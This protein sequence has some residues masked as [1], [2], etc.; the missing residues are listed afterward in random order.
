MPGVALWAWMGF[1]QSIKLHPA[2]GTHSADGCF[3]WKFGPCGPV[4][5]FR[6]YLLPWSGIWALVSTFL[7]EHI[8]ELVDW[9]HYRWVLVS[10]EWMRH[11][12]QPQKDR[13][14]AWEVN[15]A[16]CLTNQAP[17]DVSSIKV[18]A[19]SGLVLVLL[20]VTSK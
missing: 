8:P 2:L 19:A 10:N 6:L 18:R 11:L 5:T 14:W 20:N 7:V 9:L 15:K 13:W 1:S 12:T 4:S 3:G 16:S 17:I